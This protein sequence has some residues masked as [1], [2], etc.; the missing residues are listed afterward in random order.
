MQPAIRTDFN[1]LAMPLLGLA[2]NMLEQTGEFRPFGA[3]LAA[4]GQLALIDVA[5]TVPEPSNPLIIDALYATFRL[6][7]RAGTIRACAVCWDALVARQEGGGLMDAIAIGLEH[8][9]GDP[10]IVLCGYEREPS[11]DLRFEDPVT[12]VGKRHVFGHVLL[13]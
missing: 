9:D 7:A 11:G 4:G 10:T 1:E 2:E 8:R 3:R 12:A 5:P 6:E 13:S